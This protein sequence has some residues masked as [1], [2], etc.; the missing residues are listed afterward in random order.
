MR[1]IV[2]SVIFL[3]LV[4]VVSAIANPAAEFCVGQGKKYEIKIDLE[5]NEYGECASWLIKKDAWDFYQDKKLGVGGV[6][7]NVEKAKTESSEKLAEFFLEE[8]IVGDNFSASS[9]DWRDNNGN[10]IT[11]IRDQGRC[12]SCWAFSAV[13]VVE[14]R[15]NINLNNENYDLDLSE[16]DLVSCSDAGNCE[17]GNDDLALESMKNNGIVRESCFGYSGSNEGCEN[18]CSNWESEIVKINY[19]KISADENSIKNVIS[20]IGPVTAYMIVCNDFAGY[21]GGIYTSDWDDDCYA[22]W[23]SKGH[24]INIIG[25]DDE[26][27]YW[28]GKNSWGNGWGEG[29]YFKMGYSESVYNYSEWEDN[30]SDLRV[31]FLDESYVVTMTDID[32]DGIGDSL[33]NCPEIANANQND[34]DSDGVGNVCDNCPEMTNAE[35]NDSDENGVGDSCDCLPNWILNNNSCQPNDSK[36]IVYSDIN[37]CNNTYNFPENNGTEEFCDYCIPNWSEVVECYEGDY[38]IRW[39]NDS[40]KCFEN[41]SLES[42][43]RANVIS[44]FSCDFDSDGII[45]K[46]D[47]V[48]TSIANLSFINK[49]EGVEFSEGNST[50]VEF[51]FNFSLAKLNLAEVRISKQSNE[52]YGFVIINGIDLISQNSTKTIYLD[53]ILNGTGICVK[54]AGISL[55]SEISWNCSGEN[56][57]W[58]NCPGKSFDYLCNLTD[59]ETRYKIS[60]LRHSGVKEQ[61]TYCGDGICNGKEVCG[62]CSDCGACVVENNGGGGGG[63]GGSIRKTIVKNVTVVNE[64]INQTEK[65]VEESKTQINSAGGKEETIEEN[66]QS[67]GGIGITGAVIELADKTEVRIWTLVMGILGGIGFVIYRWELR[68]KGIDGG[69]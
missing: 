44:N 54:D 62:E 55:V 34:E 42:D 6:F 60:G 59:N 3:M 16:Q 35:Q 57:T 56:E 51:D 9:F 32:S 28:I 24:A 43:F 8:V 14:S 58:L 63:G 10:W 50:L 1:E 67:E 61:S 41:T 31:F 20:T 65:E 5:G 66:I 46:I 30:E 40:E 17:G 45:G 33:D 4:G 22:N 25:Y 13:G 39:F 18:K 27:E 64:T 69:E 53:R 52:S 49:S 12:G 11:Q 19:T 36:L 26:G 15:I 7:S 47:S 23:S 38:E 29:G 68:R 2:I 21:S 48:N 37:Y